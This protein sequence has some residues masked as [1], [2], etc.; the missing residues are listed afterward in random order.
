MA[1]LIGGIFASIVSFFWVIQ[2][3]GTMVLQKG[4]PLFLFID[5]WLAGMS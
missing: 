5:Q 4:V 2:M 1:A 3:M